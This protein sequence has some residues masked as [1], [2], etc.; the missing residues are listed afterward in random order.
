MVEHQDAMP[1]SPFSLQGRTA[2]VVGG[3]SGIGNA[4]AHG[5]QDSGARIAIAARTPEKVKGATLRLQEKDP[6]AR[7]YVVD[8]TRPEEI[9]RLA[10]S[11]LGDF[12]PV[13][14]LVACQGTTI[15]KPA[16]DVTPAEYDEI[17]QTNLRSVFFTCTRFGRAMLERGSGSIITVA[18]LS[19]HRGWPLASVY[20]ASKHGVVGLTKTLAAEWAERG[21][22]VNAISPGFFM[23]EL[24]QSKMS[25]KRKENALLR[26]PAGRFGQRDELVG[27][28][29][30]LASPASGFVTGTV[31]NVDGGYLASGI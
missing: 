20:A 19:A 6:S 5:F 23:T 22:R 30:Y 24:N 4:I 3:S 21:V 7:G 14:V 13:D 27:A 17:M 18:S 1:G 25:P 28:A 2:L 31:L 29:I 9:D 11:V 12:G 15:L 10:A 8:A 16:E 26:T